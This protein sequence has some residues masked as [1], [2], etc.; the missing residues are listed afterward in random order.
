LGKLCH[1][2]A[3]AFMEQNSY[4]HHLTAHKLGKV[5]FEIKTHLANELKEIDKMVKEIMKPA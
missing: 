5:R 4:P 3:K 1:A 2:K